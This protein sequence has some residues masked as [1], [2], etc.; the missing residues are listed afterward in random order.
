M[1]AMAGHAAASQAHRARQLRAV[2][3]MPT[4]LKSANVSTAR[5]APIVVPT[6]HLGLI[7]DPIPGEPVSGT[8]CVE[9]K[10]RQGVDLLVPISASSRH[11]L[12]H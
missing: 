11:L 3:V 2:H 4:R 8:S 6:R 1:S 10:L 7:P 9:V 12:V 5:P